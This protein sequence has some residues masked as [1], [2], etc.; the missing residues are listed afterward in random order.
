M[1]TINASASNLSN[2]DQR[3]L[4]R[5]LEIA[6]VK[7]ARLHRKQTMIACLRIFSKLGYDTD[8][9]GH[10]AVRDPEMTD[11]IW[12][13]PMLVPFACMTID[14][15][16]LMDERGNVLEGNHPV[17]LGA[18][19]IHSRIHE[20]RPHVVASVHLHSRFGK[21]WSS[22]GRLLQPTDQDAC[23]FYQDHALYSEYNGVPQDLDEGQAITRA[24]GQNNALILQNHGLLAVGSS[25]ESAAW[26]YITMERA[27]EAQLLIASAGEP[28]LIPHEVA[29]GTHDYIASEYSAW[30]SM[31]PAL[32]Q[33][34][35][36]QPSIKIEM[37]EA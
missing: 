35:A 17:N 34:T 8:I 32:R 1:S 21:A 20:A 4:P 18:Y 28:L 9:A 29:V 19:V 22:L 33:V 12:V 31:Q 11:C 23:A 16:I 24:L 25:V 15:L 27:C 6:D 5:P 2:A 36:E 10:F 30:L 14:D 26:R 37:L 13:N 7:C 3:V